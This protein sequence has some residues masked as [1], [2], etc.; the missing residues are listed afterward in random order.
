MGAARRQ[1]GRAQAAPRG[2]ATG[3]AGRAAHRRRDDD[4]GHR[5]Q[6]PGDYLSANAL[7]HPLYAPVFESREQLANCARFT[8]RDPAAQDLYAGWER[9]AKDLVAHLRSEARRNPYDP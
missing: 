8:F 5:A 6:Q 4:P 7:G 3:P 2:P 1:P 9:T